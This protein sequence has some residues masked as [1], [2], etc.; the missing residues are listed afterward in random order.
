MGRKGKKLCTNVRNMIVKAYRENRNTSEL[1]RTLELLRST[2]R[3]IV[4]FKDTGHVENQQGR[5][6]KRVFTDRDKNKIS[7][8]VKENRRRSYKLKT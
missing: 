7:C 2:I 4:K 5:G 3:S 6:R 1:E 8:V